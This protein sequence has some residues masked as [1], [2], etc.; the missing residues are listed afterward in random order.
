MAIQG[1]LAMEKVDEDK[2]RIRSTYLGEL[3]F[4]N[5]EQLESM[6][7]WIDNCLNDTNGTTWFLAPF[8]DEK[9]F[10]PSR[11]EKGW[12]CAQPFRPRC[13]KCI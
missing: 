13:P 4:W 1:H 11:K 7:T 3:G 10:Y 6:K 8:Q 9:R 2:F 12:T 5:R